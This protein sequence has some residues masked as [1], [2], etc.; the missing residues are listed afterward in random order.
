TFNAEASDPVGST[1][2]TLSPFAAWP[3]RVIGFLLIM[4]GIF[5]VPGDQKKFESY[6]VHWW[7]WIEEKREAG[8]KWQTAFLQ[9]VAAVVTRGFD[10]LFGHRLLSTRAVVA[11][12]TL[13]QASSLLILFLLASALFFVDPSTVNNALIPSCASCVLGSAFRVCGYSYATTLGRR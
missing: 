1:L 5:A 2:S 8:L 7:V 3:L 12:I 11:S 10:R 9:V 13:S 4:Y 6:L